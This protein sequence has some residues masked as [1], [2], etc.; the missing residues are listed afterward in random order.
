[1]VDWVL[2]ELR[3]TSGG[4]SSATIDRRIARQAGFLLK[5]GMIVGIDGITNITFDVVLKNDLY[6]IIWH[7]NHLGVMSA[8]PLVQ[9]GNIHSYDFSSGETQVYGDAAGHKQ[10]SAGIWGMIAGDGNSDQIINN[11][12]IPLWKNQAGSKGYIDA[13]YNLDS[14]SNNKDKND[15]WYWNYD[16]ETQVPE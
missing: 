7:R 6:V 14:Q 10:L 13:D 2:I 15:I 3:E 16:S 12:D 4:P 8:V 11:I 9:I 1:V 5:N